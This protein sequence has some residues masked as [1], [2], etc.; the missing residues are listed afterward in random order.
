MGA[1][2]LGHPRPLF[3]EPFLGEHDS[4]SSATWLDAGQ[5]AVL[6]QARELTSDAF[7]QLY[8]GTEVIPLHAD[9]HGANLTWHEGRLAIFD[10]DDCGLGVPA[11]D[12]ATTTFYLRGP[13]PAPE[14]ALRAGYAEVA[15]LPE[16]TE[17]TFEAVVASRQLLLAAVVL[18]STTA[19][20]RAD[21]QAYTVTAVDRLHHWLTTGRFSLAVG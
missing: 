5:Q 21:A 1:G 9:L 15:P 20:L 3:D 11:L 14:E 2:A 18:N 12:L 6:R 8:T 7:A 13:D 4:L 19:G 16:V 17:A 10:F